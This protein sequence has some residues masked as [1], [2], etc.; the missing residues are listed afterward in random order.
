MKKFEAINALRQMETGFAV[1]INCPLIGK[2]SWYVKKT[3]QEVATYIATHRGANPEVI[4]TADVTEMD[5]ERAKLAREVDWLML[6]QNIRTQ[7]RNA[8][9]SHVDPISV[10][11]NIDELLGYVTGGGYEFEGDD[12]EEAATW[13]KRHRKRYRS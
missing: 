12:W 9:N 4:S 6:E 13:L 2:E 7:L 3:V 10:L 5:K 11:A 1:K 8:K